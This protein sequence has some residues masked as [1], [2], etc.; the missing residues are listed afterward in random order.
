M[1]VNEQEVRSLLDKPA[2]TS[3][4]QDAINSNINRSVLLVNN[5]KNTSASTNMID[6]GVKALAVWLSYGTYMEGISR[7]L[8]NISEAD[9]VKLNHYMRVAELFLA[10]IS[11]QPVDLGNPVTSS[12]AATIPIDPS[13]FGLT[14]TSAFKSG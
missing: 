10:Q 3:V 11:S 7:Q 5:I 6:E 13:A 9:E 12:D 8:G 2:A 4:S 1:A 14:A